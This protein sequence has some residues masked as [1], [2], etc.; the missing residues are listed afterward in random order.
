M[1]HLTRDERDLFSGEIA[2]ESKQFTIPSQDDPAVASGVILSFQN[3]K[4]LQEIQNYYEE[5]GKKLPQYKSWLFIKDNLL[6]QINRSVP[7][8][9]AKQYA[10]ALDLLDEQ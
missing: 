10:E 7:Q 3:Q 2:V 1:R 8:A 9:V 5:M 6:L 4:D